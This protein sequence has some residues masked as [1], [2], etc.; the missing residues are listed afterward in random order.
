MNEKEKVKSM[1]LKAVDFKEDA[2]ISFNSQRFLASVNRSYYSIFTFSRSLVLSKGIDPK[3]HSGVHAKL[4]ELFIK[5]NFLLIEYSD[6]FKYGGDL[7]QYVDYDFSV[8]VEPEKVAII[9]E[10]VNKIQD[11]TDMYLTENYFN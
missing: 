2:I 10:H 4:S 7:R 6:Y 5:T 8:T 11:W 9:L 1:F 3:T